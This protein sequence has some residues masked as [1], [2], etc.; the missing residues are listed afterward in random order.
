VDAAVAN[1]LASEGKGRWREC[2]NRAFLTRQRRLAGSDVA[3]EE[4][5][6]GPHPEG[7]G[8]GEGAVA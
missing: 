7:Q 3:L 2:A 4:R 5:G 1:D 8:G 6:R